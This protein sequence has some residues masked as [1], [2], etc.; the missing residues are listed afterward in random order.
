MPKKLVEAAVLELSEQASNTR[1]EINSKVP[2]FS[3][4]PA[5]LA[6]LEQAS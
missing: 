3:F 1:N 4:T 6:H 5:A 2:R